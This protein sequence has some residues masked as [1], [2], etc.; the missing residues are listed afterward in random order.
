[1]RK[2]D[3]IGPHIKSNNDTNKIM[4]RL[5]IAL[6]P[7]VCFAIFKNTIISYYKTDSSIISLLNPIFMI[8]TGIITSLLSEYLYIK[9][10]LRKSNKVTFKELIKSYSI[11][12]GLFV[13]LLLPVNTPLWIVAFG[14]FTSSIIGKML[15]GGLGQNIFNPALVGYLLI[16]ASYSSL[17]GGYLN[18]YELDAIASSTP[19]TNLAS[20]N[21][22][23]T[24]ETLISPYG[25]LFNFL[26]GTIPG[27]LGEVSKI[28]II[29]AFIYLTLTKTIKWKIPF[30]YVLT[31]FIMTF[32]IGNS[33]NLGIWYPTFHILSGGL[34]FGAVFM[35]TDP[36]TSPITN[37]GQV[38]YGISLGILTVILRFLTPYP[39]GVA[40]SILFMNLL[41][42]LFDKIGLKIKYNI[43]K[44]WIPILVII[45]IF[46]SS[47]LLISNRLKEAK[48][49][50]NNKEVKTVEILDVKEEGNKKI[51]TVSSKGWGI[52]K[53]TVDVI[54]KEIKSIIV[55]DSSTETQWSEI[56]KAN[57]I[58]EVINNQNNIDELDA[59]SGSTKSS[60]A[61]KNIVRKIIEE[62]NNE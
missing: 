33:V 61:L 35:A 4:T 22:F 9:I 7:I 34:L 12:P 14:A 5:I 37:A 51:Y 16:S 8:F 29:V 2:K 44:I 38:L 31:V 15:F 59:V 50:E 23:G 47:V 36:V 58:F 24:Y 41:V 42:F 19:L 13:A 39:E 11:I 52:I 60:D 46:T 3:E 20:L 54:D 26:F 62:E 17:I 43:K 57:Y 28:L 6:M 25:N 49:E 30:M 55:T 18:S 10:V 1:M 32:L 21:Y 53:A 56:E 48:K 40:T 45:I 27:S